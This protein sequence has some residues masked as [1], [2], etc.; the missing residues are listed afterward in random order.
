MD[1][2]PKHP[3]SAI[4]FLLVG[5][6]LLVTGAGIFLAAV[7]IV[8]CPAP[9]HQSI[10]LFGD[11]CPRCGDRQ[12]ITLYNKW[13]WRPTPEEFQRMQIPDLAAGHL[14]VDQR[15]EETFKKIED[16]I[17]E[18]KTISVTI[19]R[20]DT[21]A[22]GEEVTTLL[23]KKGNKFRLE[24]KRSVKG[25]LCETVV[26]S[27]G[28][29]AYTQGKPELDAA[30]QEDNRH[31]VSLSR[32]GYTPMTLWSYSRSQG[33]V[34]MREPTDWRQELDL[35]N[36]RLGGTDIRGMTLL[37]NVRAR[38]GPKGEPLADYEITTWY[39]P[40]TFRPLR[41]KVEGIDKRFSLTEVY[42][43]LTL[44]ADIPDEKFKLPEEKK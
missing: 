36:V 22:F 37:Y 13:L 21:D 31:Q 35:S 27:D 2:N 23:L 17:L 26:I 43:N 4:A 1:T 9:R 12:T 15:A 11:E 10:A 29:R 16:S 40:A 20:G 8:G 7:P 41:R 5:L 39:D 6:V 14:V 33:C 3:I 44:N 32:L 24:T 19:R 30:P 34:V 38:R 18:A 28:R 25:K 42:E